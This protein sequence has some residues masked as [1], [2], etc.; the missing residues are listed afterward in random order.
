MM[1]EATSDGDR[2]LEVAVHEAGHAVISR[3]VGLP[4]G[5]ATIVDDRAR[6]HCIDDNDL[7]SLLTCLAGRAAVRVILGYD[8][9]RGCEAD[10]RKVARLLQ[11]H[12]FTIAKRTSLLG[13]C[14][15]LVRRHRG[16]VEAVARTLLD[17]ET[18][19]GWEIDQIIARAS[20]TGHAS[21]RTGLR[22]V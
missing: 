10:D 16:A 14:R 8:T 9:D 21:S 19:S 12:G 4:S 20:G 13:E 3:L 1:Q 6:S 11:A 7:R 2:R 17:R 15:Q 18:L 22:G 5:P